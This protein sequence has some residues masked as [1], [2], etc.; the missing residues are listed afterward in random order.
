MVQDCCAFVLC[1]SLHFVEHNFF[2]RS[3]SLPFWC[4]C[5]ML[6]LHFNAWCK[7]VAFLLCWVFHGISWGGTFVLGLSLHSLGQDPRAMSSP[8][9]GRVGFLRLFAISLELH[10]VG[11]IV[12]V[13]L[14]R[15]L[16][17]GLSAQCLCPQYIGYRL[18]LF[19]QALCRN[20]MA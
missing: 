3:L 14:P 20:V 8:A 4:G 5:F 11:W 18:L 1:L 17:R 7:F 9:F 19:A 12:V 13:G 15:A 6:S 16:W 2:M 10:F